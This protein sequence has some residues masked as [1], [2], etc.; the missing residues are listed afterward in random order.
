MAEIQNRNQGNK[1]KIERERIQLWS[2]CWEESWKEQPG[3]HD[4][5]R[6]CKQCYR[7]KYRL[8]EICMASNLGMRWKYA[9]KG[10]WSTIA[11]PRNWVTEGWKHMDKIIWSKEL[12]KK[13]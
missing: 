12:L 5:H 2:Y 1:I 11:R 6:K 13:E 8:N 3:R 9:D 7:K 4:Q 10:I